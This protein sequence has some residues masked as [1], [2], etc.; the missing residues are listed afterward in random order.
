ML[1]GIYA[2]A[3]L[4]EAGARHVSPVKVARLEQRLIAYGTAELLIGENGIEYKIPR[5]NLRIL[6]FAPDWNLMVY[7]SKTKMASIQPY[8]RWS[9]KITGKELLLVKSSQVKPATYQSKPARLTVLSLLPAESD[10]SK[11]EFIYRDAEGRAQQY[12]RIELLESLGTNIKLKPQQLE[13]IRWKLGVPQA[14]GLIVR[15]RNFYQSGKSDL[16][17]DTLS[18]SQ[19]TVVPEAWRYPRDYTPSSMSMVKEEKKKY[20]Q[21]A[22]MFGTLILDKEKKGP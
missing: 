9:K 20:M 19:T 18:I 4:Q 8:V 1:V 11:S 21:A 14:G 13:F 6:A 15:Q 22:E 12:N 2:N 3:F 5:Q 10:V 17:L 7:N 16:M